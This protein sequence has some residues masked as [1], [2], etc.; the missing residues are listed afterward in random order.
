MIENPIVCGLTSI[1]LDHE[2]ILGKTKEIIAKNKA[3]IIKK[4][5]V[6]IAC[7]SQPREI[8]EIFQDECNLVGSDFILA[9]DE[10]SVMLNAELGIHGEHQRSNASLA[11]SICQE[12]SCRMG[13]GEISQDIMRKGLKEA[14]WPGRCQTVYYKEKRFIFDGAHTVE[15]IQKL[16]EFLERDLTCSKR[17]PSPYFRILVFNCTS[18][19]DY[20]KLLQ[21]L[22]DFHHRQPFEKIIICPSKIGNEK[23]FNS[24]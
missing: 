18:D 20:R 19:R 6:A 7:K 14:Y 8:L 13:Y 12:W 21:P 4:N 10:N 1:G 23:S 5:S 2:N 22:I 15:S 17:F 24:K 11:M 9:D 16:I 3:G